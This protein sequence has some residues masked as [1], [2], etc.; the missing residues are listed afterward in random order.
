M[1]PILNILTCWAL[2]MA[3]K[4][5]VKRIW[6]LVQTWNCLEALLWDQELLEELHCEHPDGWD[7]QAS[8]C[9]DVA[10]SDAVVG[11]FD[12]EV[13]LTASGSFISRAS[14]E[15][16]LANAFMQTCGKLSIQMPW[17]KG[18][19]KTVFK[20][21]GDDLMQVLQQPRRWVSVEADVVDGQASRTSDVIQP[22]GDI[23]GAVF[24]KANFSNF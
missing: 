10:G 2:Q 4:R 23:S 7:G 3:F 17:E 24:E 12:L 14:F 16:C 13:E 11:T 6:P 18:P 21:P 8:N 5:N 19:L 1:I 20:K 15:Q 22:Q 9:S